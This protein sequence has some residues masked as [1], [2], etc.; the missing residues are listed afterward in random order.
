MRSVVTDINANSG[1]IP[2]L[3]AQLNYT[4]TLVDKNRQSKNTV[5]GDGAL[6]YSRPM[7]LLLRGEKDLVGKVFELGSNDREFWVKVIPQLDTEWW[8]HY[9]NLGKPGCRP[10]PIRPDLVLEVLGVS[11]FDSNFL[12]DPAPVMR[13]NNDADAYMFVWSVRG[14]DRWMAQKEIWYDRVTKLP[15]RVLLFDENGR[16]V[17][18]ANLSEPVPVEVPG[19]PKEGWPKIASNYALF[20]PDDG[21]RL[22]M[23]LTDVA[24]S[25]RGVPKTSSFRRPVDPETRDVI[26]VDRDVAN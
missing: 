19:E 1:R 26:Q 23:T 25:H 16:I 2:T 14:P 17:L 21:T 6:L 9:A 11:V 20:F 12:E 10:I 3:W 8:G 22:S 13:F 15:E 5:G 18:R 24:T 4:V 7:S